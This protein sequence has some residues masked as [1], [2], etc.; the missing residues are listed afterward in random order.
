MNSTRDNG[1]AH[2]PQPP[3]EHGRFT[4]LARRLFNVPKEEYDKEL[5]E[6]E[7]GKPLKNPFEK[8]PRK[9]AKAAP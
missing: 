4:D 3:A 2:A 8:R 6:V 5:A 7:A 9:A 1:E